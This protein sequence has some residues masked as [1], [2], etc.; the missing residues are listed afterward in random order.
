MYWAKVYGV[1]DEIVV[2]I[3]DEDLL[4]KT[5]NFK[6][7][8]EVKV[9]KGFYGDRYI[10]DTVALRLLDK[11]TIGNLM[12]KNIVKL[13]MKNGFISKEN[14]INIDGTPHAQFAKI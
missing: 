8:V 1:K 3:C 4:D 10:D 9:T 5:L 14:I 6:N 11:S 2:A 12:G 7:K 13:A